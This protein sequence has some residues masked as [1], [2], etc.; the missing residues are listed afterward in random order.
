MAAHI[1]ERSCAGSHSD[2]FV[3]LSYDTIQ[4]IIPDAISGGNYAEFL[5]AI[6]ENSIIS[7]SW[8]YE[9]IGS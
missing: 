6:D 2:A 5:T 3:T 7:I 1:A 8:G 9:S 4:A